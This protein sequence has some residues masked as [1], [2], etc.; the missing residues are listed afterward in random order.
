MSIFVLSEMI[1]CPLMLGS[2][3]CSSNAMILKDSP[4]TYYAWILLA[5]FL[6]GLACLARPSWGLWLGYG[7]RQPCT[8]ASKPH[9]E[10]GRDMRAYGGHIYCW[11]HAGHGALVDSKLPYNRKFVP[12]TLQ[13]G[14][15]L[16]DGWHA[17]A[18]GSSDEGMAF[19]DRYLKEQLE[20]DRSFE[21]LGRPKDST[22]EWRLD[23]RNEK[24]CHSVGS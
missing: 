4:R 21:A 7:G 20:E 15:S 11:N 17:G 10:T 3:L 18:T 12:S 6:T 13:V 1:F 16:Y 2:L 8:I 14:A 5:G 24:C 9:M 23:R 22:L 19:V